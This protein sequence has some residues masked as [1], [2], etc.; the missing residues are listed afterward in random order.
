MILFIL[1]IFL[2]FNMCFV[3]CLKSMKADK[4]KERLHESEKL[5]K[6]MT[7]TWEEK[8]AKTERIHKVCMKPCSIDYHILIQ[9]E[10]ALEWEQTSVIL[11]QWFLRSILTPVLMLRGSGHFDV[12]EYGRLIV[13]LDLMQSFSAICAY[14][15]CRMFY[16]A[17]TLMCAWFKSTPERQHTLNRIA[18]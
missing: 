15:C 6:E 8:L 18:W 5:M 11:V 17:M 10:N 3:C 9:H 16:R 1:I 4:L 13:P 12:H 2:D 14:Y 7:C